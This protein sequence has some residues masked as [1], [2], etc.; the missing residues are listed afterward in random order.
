V[1]N[2]SNPDAL[3]DAN[4]NKSVLN[5]AKSLLYKAAAAVEKASTDERTRVLTKQ[6]VP[7][8]AFKIFMDNI[9][10]LGFQDGLP[11]GVKAIGWK[12]GSRIYLLEI[13]L[14]ETLMAKLPEDVRGALVAT[15]A[16]KKGLHPFTV[17][18]MKAFNSK[19]W[20]VK[21][22]NGTKVTAREALWNIQAGK[23]PY[24]G[25]LILDIPS[26]FQEMLPAKDSIYAITVTGPLFSN[27]GSTPMTSSDMAGLGLVSKN[28]KS[29]ETTAKPLP[30]EPEPDLPF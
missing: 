16:A 9:N 11:K 1:R 7:D 20:L 22:V 8:L 4:G 10:Q 13:K 2:R 17:D 18:L 27:A 6:E 25:I 29:S 30:A 24:R 3:I 26:E 19:G 23:L 28:S 21:E 5:L 15:A 14:R 12:I